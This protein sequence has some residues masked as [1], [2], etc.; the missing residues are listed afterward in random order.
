MVDE[1]ILSVE[2][3]NQPIIKSVVP[4]LT[5]RLIYVRPLY[6]QGT[7][8]GEKNSRVHAHMQDRQMIA[9]IRTQDDIFVIEPSWRHL[10]EHQNLND[11]KARM[12]IY[13][14]SDMNMTALNGHINSSACAV[15]D[16]MMEMR[17]KE[18]VSEVLNHI[19]LN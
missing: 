7:V 2:N 11:N 6:A 15:D 17:D 1:S 4:V 18:K 3:P 13:R 12:I 5:F 9:N 8:L 10:P 16:L 19:L 14:Q